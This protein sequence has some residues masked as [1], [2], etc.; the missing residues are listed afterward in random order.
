MASFFSKNEKQPNHN[1]KR[2]S[3][4]M[5]KRDQHFQSYLRKNHSTLLK[6]LMQ[7]SSQFRQ[8]QTVTITIKED[9]VVD[10][11]SKDLD[12][13]SRKILHLL[14]FPLTPLDIHERSKIPTTSLYRKINRLEKDGLIMQTGTKK[15]QNNSKAALYVKTFSSITI[16]L[17]AQNS[18]VL[19]TQNSALEDSIVY[20]TMAK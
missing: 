15:V 4:H 14:E 11:I 3:N 13:E 7:T 1:D 16:Q 9:A 8:N 18:V 20:G 10:L 17:G 19:T 5:V 2:I 12:P 6:K